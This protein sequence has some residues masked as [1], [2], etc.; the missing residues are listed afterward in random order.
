MD[1]LRHGLVAGPREADRRHDRSLCLFITHSLSL[2]A[3][4]P[5]ETHSDPR[6]GSRRVRMDGCRRRFRDHKHFLASFGFVP[7]DQ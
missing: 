5:T 3:K 7:S 2:A 4:A 6:N 1:D